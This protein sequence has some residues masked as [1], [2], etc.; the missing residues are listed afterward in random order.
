MTA[1]NGLLTAAV[2]IKQRDGQAEFT[3]SCFKWI[4]TDTSATN[5]Q[6]PNQIIVPWAHVQDQQVSSM[7]SPKAMIRLR[8][9]TNATLVME[10]SSVQGLQDA[11]QTREK[12]KSFIIHALT[13]AGRGPSLASDQGLHR[14]LL[15]NSLEIKQ[16]AALLASNSNL[17]RQH[18]E[19]VNQGLISEEDFWQARRHL[20]ANEASKRQKTGKTSALLTDLAGQNEDGGNV[21][22]YNLNAEVIHQIFVQYPAIHLAYQDQVPDKLS[23][24]EFWSAFFKSKYFHRDRK[25]G[26]EDLFTK[27]EEKEQ[28]IGKTP[29]RCGS[30][31]PLIDLLTT[32]RDQTVQLLSG[33][34]H[35]KDGK[36]TIAKF[37]RHSAYVLDPSHGTPLPPQTEAHQAPN[38]AIFQDNIQEAV[39]LDDL[40]DKEAPA[41]DPLRLDDVSRYFM[42]NSATVRK[43]ASPTRLVQAQ[44]QFQQACMKPF[45]LESAFPSSSVA[46][47][48]VNE[49]VSRSNNE[50]MDTN[51]DQVL[52]KGALAADLIPNEFKKQVITQFHDVCELLRH[53]LA[54][55]NKVANS[56]DPQIARKLD[57]IVEKMGS[58]YDELVKI[59]EALPPH[60]KNLLAPLLKPF[61][62]Q[63]NLA[64]I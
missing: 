43:Q 4:P 24:T 42:H 55:K 6:Q 26:H 47:E 15:G 60:E 17:K 14:D 21:V 61:D 9:T 5:S 27:Y 49:V 46:L 34:E 20:L 10:F 37:N 39:L 53:F 7:K 29:T 32:A 45:L 2:R 50:S 62:D 8:L 31:D 23:E 28:E 63:L 35:E 41:Y 51:G 64:F 22:K 19:M 16:R 59:R 58:K 33:E 52:A 40:K 12:A 25:A 30:V 18:T 48:I 13:S 44:T 1:D 56:D 38:K 57:R 54:F 36:M 11:F 3:T